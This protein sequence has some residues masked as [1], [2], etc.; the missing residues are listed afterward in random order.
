M[1]LIIVNNTAL[2]IM[3]LLQLMT[4]MQH[5]KGNTT[6]VAQAEGKDQAFLVVQ[7]TDIRL[8]TQGHMVTLMM[9]YS[10]PHFIAGKQEDPCFGGRAVN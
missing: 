2:K 9:S 6:D 4:R 5:N 3:A 1:V 7:L 10:R 8:I